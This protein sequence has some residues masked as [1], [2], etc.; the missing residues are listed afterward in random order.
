MDKLQLK[1]EVFIAW[2]KPQVLLVYFKQVE[3]AKKQLAKWNVAVLDDDIIIHVVNQMYESD[4][5]SKDIM[6]RWEETKDNTKM[7]QASQKFFEGA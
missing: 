2:E 6:T 5:F 4:Q 1:K 7:W 3:K